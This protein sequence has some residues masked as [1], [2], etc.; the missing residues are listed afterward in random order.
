MPLSW[1]RPKE[2]ARALAARHAGEN[3]MALDPE[4]LREL[5]RRLP[6]APAGEPEEGLLWAVRALWIAGDDPLASADDPDAD[7]DE[8]PMP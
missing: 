1:S 5:I 2:L 6:G 8:E 4:R 3:L 7:T